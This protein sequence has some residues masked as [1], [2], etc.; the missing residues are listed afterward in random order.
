MR[1][2]NRTDNHLVTCFLIYNHLWKMLYRY[3]TNNFF[4]INVTIRL[5]LW[6]TAA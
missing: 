2:V 3:I 5:G 6:L 4:V 1:I